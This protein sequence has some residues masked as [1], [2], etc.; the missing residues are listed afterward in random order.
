MRINATHF[1]LCK[2]TISLFSNSCSASVAHHSHTITTAACVS[3][4][5]IYNT[6]ILSPFSLSIP[7]TIYIC[8]KKLYQKHSNN[9]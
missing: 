5:E 1:I 6:I 8:I 7:M 9:Y 4:S 2:L 3:K